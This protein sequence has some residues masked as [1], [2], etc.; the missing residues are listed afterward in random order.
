[1]CLDNGESEWSDKHVG[2]RLAVTDPSDDYY[3][4]NIGEQPHYYL[5]T[6]FNIF[7]ILMNG[8]QYEAE[9]KIFLKNWS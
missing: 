3:E 9:M 7:Q 2:V 1:M 4:D 6:V 5:L 8:R